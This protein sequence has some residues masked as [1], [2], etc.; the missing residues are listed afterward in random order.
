MG[1]RSIEASCIS[2]GSLA[3]ASC[4]SYGRPGSAS[5]TGALCQTAVRIMATYYRTAPAPSQRSESAPRHT[6][7]SSASASILQTGTGRA[8][9]GP[10]PGLALGE[11]RLGAVV[12]LAKL[13]LRCC[14]CCSKA[15]AR[16]KYT[17]PRGT[18]L[19]HASCP[20]GASAEQKQTLRLQ[21]VR[22]DPSWPLAA[23]I[24]RP[25]YAFLHAAATAA[26]GVRPVPN[27]H[28]YLPPT[29]SPGH[30]PT[31]DMLKRTKQRRRYHSTVHSRSGTSAR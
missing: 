29:S 21:L 6:Q 19:L 27:K 14:C 28:T 12:T 31:T 17:P 15:A 25:R 22:G 13:G 23:R 20:T 2:A 3:A 26:A 11:H 18:A 9:R 7:H 16:C 5:R 1:N 4:T 10:S 24:L 8:H 30:Q